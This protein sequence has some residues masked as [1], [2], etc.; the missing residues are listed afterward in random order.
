MRKIIFIGALLG[1][2]GASA[3]CGS[4]DPGQSTGPACIDPTGPNCNISVSDRSFVRWAGPATDGLEGGPST[5]V[6]AHTPAVIEP[7]SVTVALADFLIPDA[8]H[9]N[10]TL[11]PTLLTDL[12]FSLFS[13]AGANPQIARQP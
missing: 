13:P 2:L 12:H 9:P 8:N 4:G 1:G 10:T 3:A 5:A 6:V 11:D 7:G